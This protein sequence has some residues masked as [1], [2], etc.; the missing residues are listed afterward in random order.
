VS[1]DAAPPVKARGLVK[2]YKDVL[3]VDHVDLNVRAGDVYGFLGPNGAGKTT[4]LRM[5]LGLIVPTEGTVELFGRDPMRQ[6]ARALEGVAGFVEAPGFYPYLTGRKNLELLAALDGDGAA[7]RI[8]EVLEIVE[9]SPRAGHR[10]GSY[11]HGMRQRLGIASALLRSPRLLI[12]DEPATGLDPAGMRDMRRLIRRL[13]EQGMTVLLSSHQLP[14]VQEL[15]DRVAIV[16]SGRV[17]YEG[18]LSDLRRQGGAGYRLRT[19]DDTRALE[20]ARLQ[21]GI[22]RVQRDH[23]G[24]AFQADERAVGALSLALGRASIGI[25]TLTPEL[26]TLEDLFFRLTEDGDEAGGV[27]SAVVEPRASDDEELVPTR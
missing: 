11:S 7:R 5:A 12:L 6:G 8:G 13:A 17:V 22:E 9:L 15:C 18:A 2:R 1:A 25:L 20:V 26:A 21:A 24:L 14:E 16:D 23:N 10:V 27:A 4:T 19:T 3:A